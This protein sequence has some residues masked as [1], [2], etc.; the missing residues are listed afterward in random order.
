VFTSLDLSRENKRTNKQKKKQTN[1]NKQ[2]Q[3]ENQNENE[4][5]NENQNQNQQ[6][7][8][9]RTIRFSPVLYANEMNREM[10]NNRNELE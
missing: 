7:A 2:N 5:E 3:N 6:N 1:M 9:T 10:K 4:N 8:F